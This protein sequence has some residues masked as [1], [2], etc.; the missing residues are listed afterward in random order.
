MQV[1]GTHHSP[2]PLRWCTTLLSQTPHTHVDW[3]HHLVHHP[4]PRSI[5]HAIYYFTFWVYYFALCLYQGYNLWCCSHGEDEYTKRTVWGEIMHNKYS[6]KDL[7]QNIWVKKYMNVLELRH[8][9]NQLTNGPVCHPG[10]GHKEHAKSPCALPNQYIHV[11]TWITTKWKILRVAKKIRHP[12]CTIVY[13][14][15]WWCT[16]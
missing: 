3:Q 5:R 8:L 4:G 16:T 11:A 12:F 13:N 14:A 7:G 2:V 15:D 10:G 9:V 6:G 1:G